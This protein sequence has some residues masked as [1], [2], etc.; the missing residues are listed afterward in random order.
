MTIKLLQL[1]I[2]GDNYWDKLVSFLTSH[3]FDVLHL[4]ELTGKDTRSGNINSNRDVFA[5][6]Q[7]MLGDEYEGELTITQRYTSS[8]FAYMGNGTFYKKAFSL[9]EKKE[10][11]LSTYGEPFPSDAISYEGIGRKILHLTIEIEKK[12]VSFL[13][14]HFAWAKTPTEEPHQTKQGEILVNYLQ[15][16]PHPVV[17]S[18]DFN[19]DPGQPLIKKIN[20]LARNLTEENHVTNTL[21]PRTHRAKE[22]FPK[23]VAVDYIFTSRDV[24]V[25][26]FSIVE[27]DISDHFGLSVEIEI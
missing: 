2:N 17:L 10:I 19:L 18:G 1:N 16:V 5:A 24:A 15:T 7:K 22:L 12:R 26:N 13:N 9:L 21:N 14:T 20:H 11:I 8:T 6:L 4:Q 23:G 3:D 27:D 25:K